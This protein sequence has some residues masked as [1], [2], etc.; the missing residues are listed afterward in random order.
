MS[1]R[2]SIA[3]AAALCLVAGLGVSWLGGSIMVRGKSSPVPAALSPAR[4]LRLTTADGISLAATYWPGARSESP[5]I[6]LLH[7]VDGSRGATA[8]N[9]AWLATLGYAVLTIDFR[10]HGQSTTTNRS[11]GWNEARDAARALAW[12]KQQQH[13]ARVAVIGIS[14]GGAA[15]L[16]GPGGPLLADALILQAVY[17]DI[18]HAIRDRIAD[19]L[20]SVPAASLEPLLSFQSLPRFGAWPS[21]IAPIRALPSYH[22]PVMIIGGMEDRSTPPAET[23][24]MFAAASGPKQ[25]WLVEHG[26]HATICSL[27]DATYREKVSAFLARTIGAL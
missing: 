11:F 9:A 25:L 5:A 21:Q 27:T 23:R 22:G 19:R 1:V 13:G 3:I 20:G 26:D 14:M 6:L 16:I 18:R 2:R 7:G 4:D 10:G 12:L 17:P 24:A 15:S 8:P